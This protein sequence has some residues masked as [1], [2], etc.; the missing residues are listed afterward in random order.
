MI[1]TVNI[2]NIDNQLSTINATEVIRNNNKNEGNLNITN[3]EYILS[4]ADEEILILI[5]FKKIISLKSIK[6]YASNDIYID[7]DVSPPKHVN[8]YK[9]KHLNLNFDDINSL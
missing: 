9:L 4:D 1:D 8:I 6:I 2:L 5:K 7:Q 3:K